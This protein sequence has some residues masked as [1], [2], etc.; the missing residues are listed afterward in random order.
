MFCTVP[1]ITFGIAARRRGTASL[2]SSK[3]VSGVI[4]ESFG[5]GYGEAVEKPP[6]INGNAEC[7][8]VPL[9]I[10]PLK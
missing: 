10:I 6:G 1:T 2:I 4:V 9:T 3:P 8:P 7:E 5:R